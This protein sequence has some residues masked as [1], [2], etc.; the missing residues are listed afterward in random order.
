VVYAGLLSPSKSFKMSAVF[1]LVDGAPV[2]EPMTP[3]ELD[4][5]P[6]ARRS[7]RD[8]YIVGIVF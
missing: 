4:P 1:T 7:S 3:A 2:P 6:K 5:P 8:V